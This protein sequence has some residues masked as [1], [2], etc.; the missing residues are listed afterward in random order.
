MY[1]NELYCAG[2]HVANECMY[3]VNLN[4]VKVCEDVNATIIPV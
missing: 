2:G 1:C 4:S 3:N